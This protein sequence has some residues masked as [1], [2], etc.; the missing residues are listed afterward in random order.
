MPPTGKLSDEEL[1]QFREWVK[2][3]APWP[4]TVSDPPIAA[5]SA[6]KK[7]YSRAHRKN[8]GYSGLFQP[9]TPPEVKNA[10]WVRSP[11]DRFILSRLE[12]SG[13]TPAP[14]ADK[15]ALFAESYVRPHRPCFPQRKT[16]AR[17]LELCIRRRFRES[18]RSVAAS[19]RY[20]E[21]GAVT[22][23]TS[24]D[25]PTL[26]A[27]MRITEY[28]Y[29]WRYRDYVITKFNQDMPFDRLFASRSRVTCCPLRPDKTSILMA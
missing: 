21:T 29:A 13:M 5:Q 11:V 12:A 20:G 6:K 27:P 7:G 8:S 22:G 10:A 15:L 1:T 23:W 18:R 2:I 19:P 28:R 3:G 9:I 24:L 25:M 14:F 16:Y 17:F 26:Q 4:Q